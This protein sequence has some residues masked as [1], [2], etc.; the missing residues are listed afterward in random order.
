MNKIHQTIELFLQK[1]KLNKPQE[2]F[3][4]G[5]SGG[6]DSMCLLDSLQKIT[7]NKIIAIHLNHN[8][9]GVESDSEE[10]NCRKFCENNNIEFYSEKLNKNIMLISTLIFIFM[11][12]GKCLI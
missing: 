8:W 3:L 12:M 9:R 6:Y 1:H 11:K 10:K 4:V 7:K 2:V 5:F